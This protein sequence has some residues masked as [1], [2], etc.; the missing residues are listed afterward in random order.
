M[1]ANP[2]LYNHKEAFEK[3]GYI[4]WNQTRNYEIGDLIYIYCSKGISRVQFLTVVEKINMTE[5]VDDSEFWKIS[6][7]PR[8]K[9]YAR[10]RLLKYIDIP[11]LSFIFLKNNGMKYAPQS[12]CVVNSLL[13]EYLEKFFKE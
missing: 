4:D 8:K 6:D 12:P 11:E 5:I 1:S 10:L 13:R 2:L 3:N 9:R 7:I